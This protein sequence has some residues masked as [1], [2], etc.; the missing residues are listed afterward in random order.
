MIESVDAE[1]VYSPLSGNIYIEL[2]RKLT[3]AMKG[4]I[5]IKNNDKKCFLWCHIRHLNP[6]NIIKTKIIIKIIKTDKNMA[7]DLDYNDI[8]FPVSKKDYSRIEQKKKK[9]Y[10]NIFRY[11]DALTYLVCVSDQQFANCMDLLLI[12]NRNKSHYV[13]IKDFNRFMCNKTQ[14]KIKKHFYRYCLKCFSSERV[15]VELKRFV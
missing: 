15:L 7:N 9:F 10:T 2:P 6:L 13:Y 12:T 14:C 4:L 11:E 8:E 5:N 1:Y 3:N